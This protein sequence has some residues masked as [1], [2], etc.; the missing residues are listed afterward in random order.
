VRDVEEVRDFGAVDSI[1]RTPYQTDV[2]KWWNTSALII[3]NP[4]ARQV[5]IAKG[6]S[7]SENARLFALLNIAG[8]DA[9]IACW[10]SKYAYNAWRP[11]SAIRNAD[12]VRIPPDPNWLPFL[13]TPAHPEYP[14]GHSEI[15]AAMAQVLIAL[16]GDTPGVNIVAHSPAHPTFDHL[17]TQFSQGIDE[18]ING[19][20][21]EGIHFRNSDEQ[22]ARAGRCVGRFVVRHALRLRHRHHD[23]NREEAG[24]DRD[25]LHCHDLGGDERHAHD[26]NGR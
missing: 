21:W 20:V 11:I 24:A 3:W 9:G 19:R 26:D 1:V 2:A 23:L 13:A 10:D 14:S 8:A 18:V 25:D 5:A 6:L 17:W 7:L 22:G 15:S 12:G 16:F 4:V